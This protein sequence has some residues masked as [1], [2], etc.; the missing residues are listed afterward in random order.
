MPDNHDGTLI[1]TMKSGTAVIIGR[2]NSGKSTLINA[3]VGRKISI[4][5]SKPQTT[6]HRIA[7][8]MTEDRG[9]IV[10]MD[11]PGIHR[12]AYSMNRR[13]LHTVYDSLR[14][15]D[16]VVLVVDACI[17]FGAGE[18]FVLEIVRKAQRPSFLLLNKIDILD[19]TKL[20]PVIKRYS[21]SCDFLEIIPVSAKTGDNLD[22][23]TDKLFDALPEGEPLRDT[24]SIT[25]R[26]ER[27][28]AAEFIREKIL[29]RVR[30]ELPY[31]CAV[32]IRKF[33][34]ERREEKNLVVIDADILVEKR[35]QQGIILGAGASQLRDLGI[36]ARKD[37]EEL[38]GCKVF[39]G[40]QVKTRRNWRNDD[41][42]LD[43]L[44]LG[45]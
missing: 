9:Q 42:V 37:L 16:L 25:D 19:K 40:L 33:D 11:T 17:S 30:E 13:M 26:S 8:I 45:K 12:P 28:L 36:A 41:A 32:L 1:G 15:V 39:L 24:D 20:L 6:R 18:Q 43:E 34:E 21:E 14:D 22:L 7:G 2:P 29:H 3:L 5:S 38:L 44:D 27:F 23:L 4:V 10:F 35:S 31:A